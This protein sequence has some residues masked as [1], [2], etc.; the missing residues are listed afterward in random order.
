MVHIGGTHW[1]SRRM[2]KLHLL[3]RENAYYYLRRVP[4]YAVAAGRQEADQEVPQ[5]QRPQDRRPR[6]RDVLNVEYNI[7]FDEARRAGDPVGP[8]GPSYDNSDA[9]AEQ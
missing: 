2:N 6:R 3:L 7:Q 1:V 9:P 5:D 4:D 8:A